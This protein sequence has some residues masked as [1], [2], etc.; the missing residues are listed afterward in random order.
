M[1]PRI[2]AAVFFL[3]VVAAPALA[4]TWRLAGRR[5]GAAVVIAATLLTTLELLA[6]VSPPLL[7]GG[8]W[9]VALRAGDQVARHRITLPARLEDSAFVYVCTADELTRADAITVS[10][11]GQ[12]LG[13]LG[14]A[15][16]AAAYGTEYLWYRLPFSP[17]SNAPLVIE[18][19]ATEPVRLCTSYSFRPTAGE[20]ASALYDGAVWRTGRELGRLVLRDAALPRTDL[21]WR[22]LIEVRLLD[23]DGLPTRGIYY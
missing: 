12:R 4:L 9:P 10:V 23:A 3:A 13:T 7:V 19:T 18:V 16:R 6:P 5:V 1:T 22:F 21:P 20:D 11:N 8:N 2:L 14:P 15:Q 17:S